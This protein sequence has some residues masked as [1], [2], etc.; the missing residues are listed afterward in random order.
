MEKIKAKIIETAT[1]ILEEEIDV[2]EGCRTIVIL[3]Y[4]LEEPIEAFMT[5]R[6]V[7]SDT[8]IYPL[9]PAER[10]TWNTEALSRLDIEKKEYLDLAKDEIREA[11]KKIIMSLSADFKSDD[12]LYSDGTEA[13]L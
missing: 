4:K 2:V 9:K 12:G 6:V 3:H 13:D 8:D 1:K 10:A 11:C 5:L 7:A